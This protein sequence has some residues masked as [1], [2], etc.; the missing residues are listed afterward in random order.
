M[1]GCVVEEAIVCT[2]RWTRR[3]RV[4]VVEVQGINGQTRGFNGSG[5]MS[6]CVKKRETMI[7]DVQLTPVHWVQEREHDRGQFSGRK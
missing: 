4:G 5:K 3:L 2:K 6:K 7:L 1:S